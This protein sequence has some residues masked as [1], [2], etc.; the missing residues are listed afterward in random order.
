MRRLLLTLLLSFG[1]VLPGLAQQETLI[2]GDISFGGFGGPVLALSGINDKPALFVGGRG[3]VIINV[4][5]RHSISFGGGGTGLVT[6]VPARGVF[7]GKD[8]QMYL[9]LGYGG[10]ELE[11][12]NRTQRLV[13][14]TGQTLIGAGGVSHRRKNYHDFDPDSESTDPFFV[15]EPGINAELNVTTFFRVG[16]GLTYRFVSGVDLAGVSDTD[17][18]SVTGTLSLKFGG[19]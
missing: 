19:F 9:A 13:H 17:L 6:N 4:D 5:N 16:A 11:Y 7:N 12:T 1:L 14:F 3:G 2:T 10:V 15:V 8:K 18:S